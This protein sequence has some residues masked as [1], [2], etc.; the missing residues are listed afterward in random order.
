MAAD[1]RTG[2]GDPA[3]A[4]KSAVDVLQEYKKNYRSSSKGVDALVTVLARRLEPTKANA[5]MIRNMLIAP[6]AE[7]EKILIIRIAGSMHTLKNS[8]GANSGIE[9]DIRNLANSGQRDIARVATLEYSRLGY[10]ADQTEILRN[11]RSRGVITEDEYFGELAHGVRLAPSQAQ[12]ER[13]AQ[14]GAGGNRYAMEILVDLFSDPNFLNQLSPESKKTLLMMLNKNEPSFPMSLGTFGLI[15]AFRYSG[16]LHVH[17]TMEAAEQGETYAE[18]VLRRLE[19]PR[20]DPRKIMAFFMSDEGKK[21]ASQF[22]DRARLTKILAVCQQ[23]SDSLPQ[24]TMLAEATED[25]S[26]TLTGVRK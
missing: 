24:S 26:R 16:W 3:F 7:A 9:N 11:A 19:Q 22:P 12:A 13:L 8:S 2:Q 20:T 4:G 21:L 5:E 1:Q 18:I 6:A 17:A 23:Y 10:F 15:D 25:I 14:I